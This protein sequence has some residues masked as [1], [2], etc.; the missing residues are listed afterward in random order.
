MKLLVILFILWICHQFP[1]QRVWKLSEFG[2]HASDGI[3]DGKPI[4]HLI[5]SALLLYGE[6]AIQFDE[7]G[8]Y[9]TQDNGGTMINY[10]KGIGKPYLDYFYPVDC[11]DYTYSTIGDC[12]C[13]KLK[14]PF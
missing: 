5:D 3:P 7:C 6:T 14:K 10:T 11:P 2:I 9:C 4:Q 13:G 1:F 8:N 12:D